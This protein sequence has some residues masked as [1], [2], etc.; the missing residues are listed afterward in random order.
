[1]KVRNGYW[2]QFPFLAHFASKVT[3]WSDL[4]S[5]GMGPFSFL[6]CESDLPCVFTVYNTFVCCCFS[7]LVNTCSVAY[8]EQFNGSIHF[9]LNNQKDF[10]LWCLLPASPV[11]VVWPFHLHFVLDYLGIEGEMGWFLSV[12]MIFYMCNNLYV[13]WILVQGVPPD[14]THENIPLTKPISKW[15]KG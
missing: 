11:R 8:L 3:K 12:S 10:W 9:N 13:I 4:K 6:I 2:K 5:F 7:L 15:R 1:M 14:L